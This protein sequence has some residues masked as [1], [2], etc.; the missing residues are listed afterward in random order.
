LST[1][2][3]NDLLV[4]LCTAPDGQTAEKLAD[5][6]I[7]DRLAA[8]VNVISGVKSFYRWQGKIETDSEIQLI[9][10]TR[11]GRLDEVAAWLTENHPYDV[12]EIIALPT[13]RVSNEYLRWVIEQT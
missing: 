2:D 12:P 9:I 4:I 13:E 6:L 8:C 1:P 11:R 10:K 5:G 7:K 3:E